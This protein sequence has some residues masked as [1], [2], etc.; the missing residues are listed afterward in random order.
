MKKFIFNNDFDLRRAF[1]GNPNA[2]FINT[3]P[4]SVSSLKVDVIYVFIV[5]TIIYC[6][7]NPRRA[8]KSCFICVNRFINNKLS[9]KHLHNAR[10][11]CTTFA[12]R[13]HYYSIFVLQFEF[14][15]AFIKTYNVYF[16]SNDNCDIESE[17]CK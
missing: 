2:I 9:D 7:L 12:K 8:L 15:I 16:N 6:W 14:A 13:D 17:K 11:R 3:T 1:N 5:S 4:Q 10:K